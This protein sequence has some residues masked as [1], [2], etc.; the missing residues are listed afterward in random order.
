MKKAILEVDKILDDKSK[1][2][3]KELDTALILPFSNDYQF[4]NNGVFF[5][6]GKMGSGKTYNVIRHIMITD[7]LS[8]DSFYDQIVISATSGSMDKTSK[9][10]MNECK[11]PVTTVS[12]SNLMDFLRKHVRQKAKYYAISKFL[13]SKMTII[14]D[15]MR[16]MINKHDLIKDNGEFDMRR[17]TNYI[18]NKL[19]K[20]SFT[21]SPSNTVLVLD[22][23]GGHKLLNKSDSPLANFITK[24]RHYNYT[25]IIMCQTWR[26]ISL[27][28]RRLC[29]DFV[30]FQG[31]SYEDIEAIVRQSGCSIP[32]QDIWEKYKQLISPRSYME[33][34]IVSNSVKFN[35]VIWNKRTIF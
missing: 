25:V 10:F 21:K 18:L 20:Y 28:I 22:D 17:L 27:N 16:A 6:V 4:C 2:N 8:E 34:H 15:D 9:T 31:Y 23:F 11:A 26:H 29:T 32:F 14:T 30:I 3:R 19:S 35:D 5:F 33:L 7:R 24:V 12:D 13:E 1:K